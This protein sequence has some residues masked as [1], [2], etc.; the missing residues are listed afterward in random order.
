MSYVSQP[1]SLVLRRESTFLV[2]SLSQSPAGARRFPLFASYRMHH[3]LLMKLTAE[4]ARRIAVKARRDPRTV[5]NLYEGKPT[6]DMPAACIREAALELGFPPP[7][8]RATK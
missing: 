3:L 2:T 8:S 1:H 5:R 4:E 6:K 7:P